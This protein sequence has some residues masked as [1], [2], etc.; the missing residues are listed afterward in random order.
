MLLFIGF[1]SISAPCSPFPTELSEAGLD[2]EIIFVDDNSRD[3]SVEVVDDLIS[4]NYNVRII[5]RTEERGLSSAVLRGFRDASHDVVLVMDADLQHDPKYIPALLAPI[6]NDKSDFSVGSRH[7]GGGGIEGWSWHR[8]FISW[9]A[10]LV[11]KP[12]I[13]C[14]DPMSGFFAMRKQT[15]QR[16]PVLNPLGYKIGLELMVRCNVTRITEVPI[17]FKDRTMGESKLDFRTNLQYLMHVA[18]LYWDCRP[19]VVLAAVMLVMMVALIILKALN[20]QTLQKEAS[21]AVQGLNK[22]S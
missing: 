19:K 2:G 11:A 22:K 5:V 4:R 6:I 12:L 7:V 9:G 8:R 20:Q 17:V 14:S 21:V 1:M 15:V 3:G 10:T 16:A 13:P 18:R